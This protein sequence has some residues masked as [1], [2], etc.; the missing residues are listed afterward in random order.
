MLNYYNKYSSF[1]ILY[2]SGCV[3]SRCIF[4]STNFAGMH[5]N[6]QSNDDIGQLSMSLRRKVFLC[7]F[8]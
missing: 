8:K 7:L 3:C 2:T 6:P 1:D 4:V 5:K